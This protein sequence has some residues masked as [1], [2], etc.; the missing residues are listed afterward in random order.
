LLL[1]CGWFH[2]CSAK[3]KQAS[4]LKKPAPA[5]FFTSETQSASA[6]LLRMRKGMTC[7]GA[8]QNKFAF[9]YLRLEAQQLRDFL[10]LGQAV[11]E[12][13]GL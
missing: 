11:G 1:H 13:I 5:G 10:I 2:N 6:L 7:M 8:R 3:T 4:A 9:H 12:R